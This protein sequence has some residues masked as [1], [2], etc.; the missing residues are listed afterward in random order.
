MGDTIFEFDK[1]LARRRIFE[2]LG[3]YDERQREALI[4]KA[5]FIGQYKYHVKEDNEDFPSWPG[6]GAFARALGKPV[7]YFIYEDYA[8]YMIECKDKNLIRIPYITNYTDENNFVIYTKEA[9]KCYIEY[10]W[11]TKITDDPMKLILFVM[12]NDSMTPMFPKCSEL[13]IDTTATRIMDGYIY[14]FNTLEFKAIR[15]RRFF[16]EL[17]RLK[18]VPQ[19]TAIYETCYATRKDLNI[20]GHVI[21]VKHFF[22]REVT[23][24]K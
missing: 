24:C 4:E 6:V 13:M 22:V 10:E 9:V 12:N 16:L 23:K 7:D 3:K 18:I 8:Y 21:A 19:N 15:I 5:G 11:L 20:L 1:K 2:E 14:A 17:D